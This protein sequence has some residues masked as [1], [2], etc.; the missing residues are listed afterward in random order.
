MS[1]ED[2]IQMYCRYISIIDDKISNEP[3]EYFSITITDS[4]PNGKFIDDTTF[5]TII[6]DDS[7]LYIIIM[8]L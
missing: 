4:I 6:D 2:T 7:K 5:I 8:T 3:D 1:R